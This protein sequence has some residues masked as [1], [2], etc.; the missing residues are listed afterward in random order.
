MTVTSPSKTLAG[1]KALVATYG[2]TT[3]KVEPKIHLE[4]TDFPCSPDKF[5]MP[6]AWK[7]KSPSERGIWAEL[8]RRDTELARA[9]AEA[10]KQ[11]K[12]NDLAMVKGQL[13]QQLAAQRARKAA[14]QK[15]RDE[16]AARLKAEERKQEKARVE[17]ER[18]RAESNAREIAEIERFRG[19]E[20]SRRRAAEQQLKQR[21]IDDLAKAQAAARTH[22]AAQAAAAAKK[23]EEIRR[24]MLQNDRELK[25]KARK[26]A[27]ERDEAARLAHEAMLEVGTAVTLPPDTERCLAVVLLILMSLTPSR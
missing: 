1:K 18:K 10:E 7:V 22:E 14:A 24:F 8:V 12:L 3:A 19:I 26:A 17:L 5:V 23:K 20:Q 16:A 11:K 6:P 2:R 4:P 27:A 15:E 25:E 21:E 9:E 13:D